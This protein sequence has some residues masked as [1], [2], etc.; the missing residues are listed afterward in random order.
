MGYYG[1]LKLVPERA[2]LLLLG[3]GGLAFMMRRR[4]Q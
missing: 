4:R 2:R 3:L 1:R